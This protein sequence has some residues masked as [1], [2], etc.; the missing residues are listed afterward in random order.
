MEIDA[1]KLLRSDAWPVGTNLKLMNVPWDESYR[2]VV[3]WESAAARDAWFDA[4]A[5]ETWV[6]NKFNYLWPNQPIAVPVPYSAAYRYNYVAV[7]NPLQPVDDEGAQRTYYYFITA[8]DYLSPQASNLT[9]QLDVMTTYCASIEFGRAFVERGHIAMANENARGTLR[10]RWLRDYLDLPEGL[11]T[12]SEYVIKRRVFRPLFKEGTADAPKRPSIIVVS[13]A[14]L[15]ADPGTVSEPNLVSAGGCIADGIPSGCNVYVL[16]DAS[17][18]DFMS[19][20]SKY[21]WVSQCIVAIYTFPAEFISTGLST[22]RLFGT[23]E[24]K[25]FANESYYPQDGNVITTDLFGPF[26]QDLAKLNIYPYSYVSVEYFGGNSL[27]LKP[28][29]FNDNLLQLSALAVALAP[30]ARLGVYPVNY[31]C[32]TLGSS[33]FQFSTFYDDEWH[34][35]EVPWA[36]F[37]DTALWITDFPQF[38][39]VN[40]QA[41]VQLASQANTLRYNYE[42]AAWAGER[43]N[44]YA[45]TAYRNAMIQRDLAYNQTYNSVEAGVQQANRGWISGLVGTGLS[46]AGSAVSAATG[47]SSAMAGGSMTMARDM[48]GAAGGLAGTVLSGI[49]GLM[50][51]ELSMQNATT[52]LQTQVNNAELA[53]SA[54][55]QIAGNNRMLAARAAIGDYAN[56]IRGIDAKVQDMQLTPPSQVGQ[57]GGNGLNLKYGLFGICVTWHTIAGAPRAALEDYFR[58]YGYAVH[59]WLKMGSL[60]HLLCMSKFAYWKV[61]E[62]TIIAADANE[63]E[64]QT[65]RGVLEKGVTLWDAPE[66]IG[67]IDLS[68]NAPRD[69]YS[70]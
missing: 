52:A 50:N 18:V 45:S 62:S 68:D 3:A 19:T 13:T 42:S 57:M 10:G 29:L 33:E 9:V 16:E 28:Q 14:V 51:T 4:Q 63:S 53:R 11:D 66:S 60:R 7:T 61:Q 23:I 48:A 24:A 12:G 1:S 54:T 32:D 69:G 22:V 67:T 27:L 38:S 6:S 25:T 15:T 58:R 70:Y 35:G 37:I 43:A 40:N 39:I 26:E 65:I 59:R 47:G 17:F 34:T 49:N 21:S 2:D 31:N 20:S 64:R 44:A 46:A 5:S 8:V 56:A 41:F 30:F 55:S 36:D